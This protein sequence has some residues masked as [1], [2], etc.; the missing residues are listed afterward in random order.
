MVRKQDNK[1]EKRISSST[2][3]VIGSV[4]ILIGGFFLSYN[5]IQS[6]RIVAYDYMANVFYEQENVELLEY[7]GELK[8]EEKE[9]DLGEVTNNYIGYLTIPKIN[10]KKG[11]L[12][13][14]SEL[15]NVEQ[16][17]TV[18]EG[19]S[20]PDKDKGN[21][22]LAAHS[23][24]GWKAFFNDLYKL[25]TGDVAT[26]SYKGKVYTY[27]IVNI[28]KQEKIGKVAIYRNYNKTTLTLITCTNFDK[29]TQ[30]IYVAELQNVEEE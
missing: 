29:A 9:D 24:S 20:Y 19:S 2:I 5:Y 23:G 22:I 11:F 26:V 17:V 25:S 10:L 3:A 12:D 30:T 27:K 18:I 15:N 28:Y 1:Q 6:K 8:E 14:R 13:M 16:N 4:I 21:L 7:D